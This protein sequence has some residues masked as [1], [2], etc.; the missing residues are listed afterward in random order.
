M[1]VSG[2]YFKHFLDTNP[3]F[4]NIQL[5]MSLSLVN[6]FSHPSL[7]DSPRS[8][9]V[10]LFLFAFYCIFPNILKK[11]IGI[12]IHI[13]WQIPRNVVSENIKT[14]KS[15]VNKCIHVF[16]LED[17]EISPVS[18]LKPLVFSCLRFILNYSFEDKIIKFTS[19]QE[20]NSKSYK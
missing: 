14:D 18:C 5:I 8:N 4:F 20:S 17:R 19:N 16:S 9:D 6:L 7:V 1:K 2:N 15:K 10:I 3:L 13:T 11:Y 12:L